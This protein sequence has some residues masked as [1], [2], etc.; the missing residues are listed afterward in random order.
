MLNSVRRARVVGHGK[1]GRK[2]GRP[3]S[4]NRIGTGSYFSG[5]C[6]TIINGPLVYPAGMPIKTCC[7]E[8]AVT[9]LAT[10]NTPT[11]A[12]QTTY[13]LLDPLTGLLTHHPTTRLSERSNLLPSS[14]VC[15]SGE[16]S[17]D[18]TGQLSSGSTQPPPQT[19]HVLHVAAAYATQLNHSDLASAGLTAKTASAALA[20]PPRPVYIQPSAI[21][22][23]ALPAQLTQQR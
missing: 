19:Q 5:S 2:P 14:E 18:P 1:R 17:F 6:G 10:A 15:L 21:A 3:R 8:P 7:S 11:A 13:A 9:V 23:T 4:V 16:A 22:L 20:S 12:V